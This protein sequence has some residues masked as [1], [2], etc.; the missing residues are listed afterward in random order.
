M[1]ENNGTGYTYRYNNF[2][3]LSKNK[4]NNEYTTAG[5][6]IRYFRDKIYNKKQ[7]FHV[8]ETKIYK[9]NK[10]YLKICILPNF[11]I[12][13]TSSKNIL[14]EKK[15]CQILKDIDKNTECAI[16][17]SANNEQLFSKIINKQFY[18]KLKLGLI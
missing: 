6:E 12:I 13:T 18:L 1:E 9:S 3:T 2:E 15:F 7:Y 10:N 14:S 17:I 4:I 5:N 16:L 8:F 11:S